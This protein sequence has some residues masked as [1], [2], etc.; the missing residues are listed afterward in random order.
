MYFY[1]VTYYSRKYKAS[2]KA[3]DLA[4]A[5]AFMASSTTSAQI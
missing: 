2:W 3:K 4:K 5:E 1:A